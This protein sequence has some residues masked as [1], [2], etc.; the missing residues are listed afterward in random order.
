MR[1][2]AAE[3]H[4]QGAEAWGGEHVQETCS[5]KL[6]CFQYRKPE[7]LPVFQVIFW[8]KHFFAQPWPTFWGSRI[9]VFKWQEK[10]RCRRGIILQGTVLSLTTCS[11]SDAALAGTDERELFLGRCRKNPPVATFRCSGTV[12]AVTD[13]HYD[14]DWF[15][16]CIQ[17]KYMCH[18]KVLVK[19]NII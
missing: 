2:S 10:G 7:D 15:D 18:G 4:V 19:F 16:G 12:I 1:Q 11:S 6:A 8:G 5:S 17:V 14:C 9:S 3:R 13:L